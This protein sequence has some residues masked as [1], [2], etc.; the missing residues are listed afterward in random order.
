MTAS[1]LPVALILR[2]LYYG[3]AMYDLQPL[4]PLLQGCEQ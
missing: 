4:I 3:P 2:A 1:K